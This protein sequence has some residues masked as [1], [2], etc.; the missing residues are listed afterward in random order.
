M[1]AKTWRQRQSDVPFQ[2]PIYGKIGFCIFQIF[3]N[4]IIYFFSRCLCHVIRTGKVIHRR[5]QINNIIKD[6]HQI[7]IG[8]RT[9]ITGSCDITCL[10]LI[11]NFRSIRNFLDHDVRSID[12]SIKLLPGL[13][14]ALVIALP[15][16]RVH[17]IASHII[18]CSTDNSISR[19][20]GYKVNMTFEVVATPI[21]QRSHQQHIAFSLRVR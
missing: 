9:H 18:G 19:C 5:V 8:H 21:R 4:L 13:I 20:F 17:F 2:N 10:D 12:T 7:E 11:R 3:N 1:K 14:K 6:T 16:Q 15:S